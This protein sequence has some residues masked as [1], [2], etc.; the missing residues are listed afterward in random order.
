[1]KNNQDEEY[2][3]KCRCNAALLIS[4]IWNSIKETSRGGNV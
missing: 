1:M 4:N 3:E 2:H